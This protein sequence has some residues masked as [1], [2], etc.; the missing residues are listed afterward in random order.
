MS[1]SPAAIAPRGVPP[2][3]ARAYRTIGPFDERTLP[4]GLR[5]EHRL[6]PGAWARIMLSEG[7]IRFVWDDGEGGSHALHAPAAM[8][9]PPEVPHHL[10]SDGPFRL[11][12]EFIAA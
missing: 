9:V 5:G 7:S 3:G 12:I 8:F 10:E 2:P 1:A 6:K 11:A 4:A